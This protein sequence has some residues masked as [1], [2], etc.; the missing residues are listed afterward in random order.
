MHSAVC[1]HCG[2]ESKDP[3]IEWNFA[4]GAVYYYCP[5]CSQM[6]RMVIKPETKPLPRLRRL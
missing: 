4:E 3:N 6:N 1:L 2:K 5:E